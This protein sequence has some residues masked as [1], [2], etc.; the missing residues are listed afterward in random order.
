MVLL[1][2]IFAHRRTSSR[3]GARK[4]PT[5]VESSVQ[6]MRHGTFQMADCSPLWM[7]ETG[8]I[9][10]IRDF[11]PDLVLTH[12][13]CD[14]HPDHRAVGQ[15]VQDASYMVTVPHIVPDVQALRKDPVGGLHARFVY[16]SGFAAPGR[17]SEHR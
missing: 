13:P 2:T 9:R 5:P 1:V 17:H 11:Q 10:E 8:I 16:P 14:Y 12:R 15:C 7:F 6:P 3:Y 4:L